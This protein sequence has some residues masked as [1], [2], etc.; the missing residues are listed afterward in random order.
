MALAGSRP[1]DDRFVETDEQLGVALRFPGERL[2]VFTVSFGGADAGSYSL[3]G[4]R[5]SLR[6]DSAYEYAAPMKLEIQ[7][8]DK[9]EK[10]SFKKRDQIAAELEY[11]ADCVARNREPEPSGWEGLHDV[12]I[13]Q[14]ILESARTG[15]KREIEL[16]DKQ[17]TAQRR[18]GDRA[19]PG[20]APAIPDQ[21]RAPLGG[22][23]TRPPGR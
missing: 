3:V 13:I 20:A 8:G 16:P 1:G 14:T 2:A 11:F 12:R 5:G 7:I 23:N 10:R 17:N 18:A 19:P 4:T 21:R 22:L 15:R 9:T 6:L